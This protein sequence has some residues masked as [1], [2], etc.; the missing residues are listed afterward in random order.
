MA[1][2][3]TSSG[4]TITDSLSMH[5]LDPGMKPEDQIVGAD[6]LMWI[7]GWTP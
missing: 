5:D 2:T 6:S 4:T 3:E 7:T 1:T